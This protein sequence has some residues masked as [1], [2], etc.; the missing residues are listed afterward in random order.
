M[1][2]K[3]GK[4]KRKHWFSLLTKLVAIS[5]V[6]GCFSSIIIN[7]TNHAQMQKELNA[8]NRKA[9]EIEDENNEL[10]R[11]LEDDGLEEYMEKL[12]IES[13]NYAYPDERRYYDKSRN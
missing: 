6:I 3:F 4:P 11:I 7:K 1:K 10:L 12:A 13:M 2:K 8:I 5:A 9:K